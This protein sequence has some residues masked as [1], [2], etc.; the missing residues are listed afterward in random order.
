MPRPSTL[1]L[2]LGAVAA[3]VLVHR[4]PSALAA[5]EP[6][7]TAAATAGK[8]QH[9][10]DESYS[11]YL[12]RRAGA[13]WD[14]ATVEL[15]ASSVTESDQGST[16]SAP[17]NT[18]EKAAP[19]T[20]ADLGRHLLHDQADAAGAE[21][22]C[23]EVVNEYAWNDEEEHAQTKVDALV[24]LGEARLALHQHSYAK[25]QS[26]RR[27]SVAHDLHLSQSTDKLKSAHSSLKK[28]VSI[29]PT[30]AQARLGM[31]TT[32]MLTASRSDHGSNNDGET[33]AVGRLLFDATQ[34]FEAAANI[35]APNSPL[36]L[37]SL[38]N[39]ALAHLRLGD[40]P[41]AIIPMQAAASILGK[42][43][44]EISTFGAMEQTNLGSAMV[45]AG[46]I[47][48]GMQI[49]RAIES[50]HCQRGDNSSIK[51]QS[52]TLC[53]IIYNNLGVA[54]EVRITTDEREGEG[55]ISSAD[56]NVPSE[57][58]E[59][60]D[61]SIAAGSNAFNLYNRESFIEARLVPNSS[62]GS[63]WEN[64]ADIIH[65]PG[66]SS[67]TGSSETTID[68]H[69]KA[70]IETLEAIVDQNTENSRSWVSL[71][72][73]RARAGDHTGA[74]E[75]AA[76]GVSTAQGRDEMDLANSALED[77]LSGLSAPD[78]LVSA[79]EAALTH[80]T[81]MYSEDGASPAEVRTLRLEQEVLNLKFQLLEQRV[82]GNFAPRLTGMVG[83]RNHD[84]WDNSFAHA[85]E[86][87]N[88]KQ[89]SDHHFSSGKAMPVASDSELSSND[90]AREDSMAEAES[91]VDNAVDDQNVIDNEDDARDKSEQH[92]GAYGTGNDEGLE[93]GKERSIGEP[94]DDADDDLLL[95]SESIVTKEVKR[96]TQIDTGDANIKEE[97]RKEAEP[98]VELPQL[99]NPPRS[100]P[101][102][103]PAIV[104][105]YMKLA[106]AYMQK[107]NY[108][109]AQRQ[110]K[111]V[112]KKSPRH[113]PAILG[114][115]TAIERSGNPK[116]IFE[117]ALAYG[118][119]TKAA[120][121]I[122]D[123][124]L[125][126]I[127]LR[128][129]ITLCND[130]ATNSKDNKLD[131]FRRL[132][133]LAF[134]SELAAEM[135]YA[136]GSEIATHILDGGGDGVDK[137]ESNEGALRAFEIANRFACSGQ[138]AFAECHGHGGSLSMLARLTLTVRGDAAK[139]LSYASLVLK[140]DTDDETKIDAHVI[141]GQAKMVRINLLTFFV[142][143][144]YVSALCIMYRMIILI[145]S[146]SLLSLST[147]AV[148]RRC[149]GSHRRISQCFGPARRPSHRRGP[150][151]FGSRAP[152]DRRRCPRGGQ[153]L[154]A[155]PQPGISPL[156]R[157]HRGAR[158][159]FHRHKAGDKS[160]AMG[161]IRARPGPAV[162]AARRN[163]EWRR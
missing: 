144:S 103:L 123:D 52:S 82:G 73:T 20:G 57:A 19:L 44:S 115:A 114:Y 70:A 31:G 84:A 67:P 60:Y 88:G 16:A 109:L 143:G 152:E 122:G 96:E 118:N 116:Q 43:Y 161:R 147:H 94:E 41:S 55:D 72:K 151:S 158:G 61:L 54:Y 53:A 47:G 68:D 48:E 17:I 65:P 63:K 137:S 119:A 76:R 101:P 75:A 156:R 39:L 46:M 159:G 74:L 141:A 5:G 104:P 37:T 18:E 36:H 3:T 77:A 81:P 2:I 100:P 111:K 117:V 49:L 106:D 10:E 107:E 140:G 92:S 132:S 142:F 102:E 24:C 29:D 30:N 149:R 9:A 162:P 93:I 129:A 69:W 7:G 131:T 42:S 134:T 157:G 66:S 79:G 32:M 13:I 56:D 85:D 112:L 11:S 130:A 35:S 1:V 110:F 34:H 64:D 6:A 138:D 14:A 124:R 160:T 113:I 153:S 139:S 23:L 71:S 78:H 87:D 21:T 62:T 40:A 121:A 22:V 148:A 51:Q 136:I 8:G 128:R 90:D 86:D 145:L 15:P 127:A 59:Y 12:W 38:H 27:G 83:Q 120:L 126:T 58:D 45:Q 91:M 125:A 108:P 155:V 133:E 50:E 97:I 105:S 4:S 98:E 135:Y 163:H 28:A 25:V 89:Q 26:A 80:P 95:E 99:Y 33:G 150:S 154:R 146:Y